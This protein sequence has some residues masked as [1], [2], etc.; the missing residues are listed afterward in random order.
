MKKT[1]PIIEAAAKVV[2]SER[3]LK[4]HE[5]EFYA[6]IHFGIN[7]F[8]DSEWGSGG[9]SPELFN[10]VKLNALQWAKIIK[11]AGMKALI[12]TCKHHDGF[13]LWPSAYTDHSVKS[14]PW[15]DGNGDVVKEAANACRAVGIKFG[16][17][18]SPWDRHELSYGT[19]ERYNEFF[20]NQLRELL[21]NYGDLFCVWFDGAC[22]EGK[23][24]RRQ[25]YDWQGYYALIRELQPNAVI[26]VCGPDVRWIGNESGVTRRSEWNV[27]PW[28][29]SNAECVAAASQKDDLAPPKK[30]SSTDLDLGSRAKIKKGH[31]LIWYPAEVDVSLRK[32]WFYHKNEDLT[33]KPLSKLAD[34]YYKSVGANASLLLNLSPN[35]DGLIAERD[36]ETLL[37]LGAQ[38]EIDFNENLAEG[39]VM[40][41]STQL[42]GDHG[43]QNVLDPDKSKYWHSGMDPEKPW[44]EIDLGDD[45]DID[46][47]VLREHIRTGQQIEEFTLYGEV[48]G[49]WKKLSEG[50]VIGSKRICRFPELRVQKMRLV[51]EQTRCFA[52]IE[53][54]EAY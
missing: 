41:C 54:F 52:A 40:T 25:E 14:S 8:T 21:T 37:S 18:L 29:Y 11:A 51:I 15:K 23:D 7:T 1:D 17:Y 38:L 12:L 16:V 31:R 43:A 48:E 49:K 36:M 28:Y 50:T 19:G 42:D 4:W 24:G 10:P 2:P 44:I 32:G 13:C 22:G 26:S 20:K 47:V 46:K 39:S 9:E 27:V 3:Q 33:V 35:Q 30:I 45:Y 53:A 5:L 34:L 6:F